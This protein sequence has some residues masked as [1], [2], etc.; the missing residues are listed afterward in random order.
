M[1]IKSAESNCLPADDFGYF[2][3]L[4][5]SKSSAAAEP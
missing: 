2:L 5:S 3:N 4:N 1:I